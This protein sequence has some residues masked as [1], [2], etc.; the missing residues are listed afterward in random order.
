MVLTILLIVILRYAF[1]LGAI[2]LQESLVWLHSAIFLLGSAYTLQNNEHVRV[3]ILYRTFSKKKQ[4][5]INTIGILVF[6]FPVCIYFIFVSWDFVYASWSVNEISRDAGGLVYPAI[7]LLKSM[8]LLMPITLFFQSL[9]ILI[10][11]NLSTSS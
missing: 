2:F 4:D 10:K 3:D 5:W 9:S 11:I 7:P 1:N 6:I 8:L